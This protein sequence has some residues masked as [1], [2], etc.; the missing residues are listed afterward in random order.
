[1]TVLKDTPCYENAFY[2]LCLRYLNSSHPV[3]VFLKQAFQKTFPVIQLTSDSLQERG[4]ALCSVKY[5]S[6]KLLLQNL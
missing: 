5:A 3:E 4:I 1:M 2:N 6:G